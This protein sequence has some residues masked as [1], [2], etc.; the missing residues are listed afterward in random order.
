MAQSNRLSRF[1]LP[2]LALLATPLAASAAEAPVDLTTHWAGFAAIALFVLAYL[3]VVLEEFTHLRK[4]QPVILAAG[5][6]LA[7]ALADAAHRA[8]DPRLR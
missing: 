2:G 4:S 7:N 5:V 1:V 3:M 6:I 8:L